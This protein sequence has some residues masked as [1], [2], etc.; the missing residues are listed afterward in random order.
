MVDSFWDCGGTKRNKFQFTLPGT[1]SFLNS[2]WKIND[3][4]NQAEIL[5][6]ASGIPP[7][8]SKPMPA[9]GNNWLELDAVFLGGPTTIG[10]IE[11][12]VA[13]AVSD[14]QSIN[15]MKGAYAE[16]TVF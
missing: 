12:Q 8:F 13:Q 1:V 3:N 5:F 11:V 7:V 9:G 6:A 15:I 14:V 4:P 10:E 2:T 16:A